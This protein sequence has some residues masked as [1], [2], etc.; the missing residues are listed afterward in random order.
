MRHW[1]STVVAVVFVGGDD[2]SCGQHAVAV[3]VVSEEAAW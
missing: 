1:G 2:N 3:M